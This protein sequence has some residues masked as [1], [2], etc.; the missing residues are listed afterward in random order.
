MKLIYHV[1]MSSQ[2]FDLEKDPAE[3]RDLSDDE[4]YQ[5][6]RSR[7]EAKLRAILDPEATDAA[8]KRDQAAKVEF[9]GGKDAVAQSGSLVFTPPP[10]VDA[11]IQTDR[12]NAT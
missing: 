11:E 6:L 10:G 1:G 8:A 3:T 2:L 9:W 7:L 12:R 4:D 5:T